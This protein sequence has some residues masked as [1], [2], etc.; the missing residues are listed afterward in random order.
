MNNNFRY[1]LLIFWFLLT[2]GTGITFAQQNQTADTL[3]FDHG[4]ET[5]WNKEIGHGLIEEYR[6]MPEY[7]YDLDPVEQ[8]TPWQRFKRWV[9]RLI[10]SF[11]KTLSFL[12]FLR[13]ILIGGL[14]VFFIV[15]LMRGSLTGLFRPKKAVLAM[16]YSLSEDPTQTDWKKKIAE[17][18]ENKAY[19]L[20]TRFHF[21][22]ILK[23]LSDSGWIHWKLEKTNRDYLYEI[24]DQD[25]NKYFKDLTRLYEAVWYGNFPILE[26]DFIQIQNDFTDMKKVM[27]N[28][29]KPV[30]SA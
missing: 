6:Q 1:I 2:A 28:K 17:A 9:S 24:K 23:L 14:F 8:E 18:L 16:S 12:W 26:G 19:R 30:A 13:Y 11:A 25:L 5:I 10:T 3:S 21:L 29:D 15:V 22:Q 20:A 4:Q 7:I 27:Q